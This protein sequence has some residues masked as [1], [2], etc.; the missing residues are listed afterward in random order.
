[1]IRDHGVDVDVPSVGPVGDLNGFGPSCDAVAGY[2]PFPGGTGGDP[3]PPGSYSIP[4]RLQG[5]A[6]VVADG[7]GDHRDLI[8]SLL[9][10]FEYVLEFFGALGGDLGRAD[11]AE[12]D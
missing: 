11:G 9:R 7:Q 6:P 12:P 8:P 2:E 10:V 1:M 4:D 5:V 3:V